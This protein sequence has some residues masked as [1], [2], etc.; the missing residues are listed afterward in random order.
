MNNYKFKAIVLLSTAIV[1][2]MACKIKHI[3]STLYNTMG[4]TL[5]SIYIKYKKG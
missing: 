5:P 1:I 4:K 2:L 3:E